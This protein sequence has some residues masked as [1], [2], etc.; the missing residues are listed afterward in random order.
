MA[1]KEKKEEAKEKV[2][3]IPLGDACSKHTTKRSIRAVKIIREFLQRHTK[4]T[5]VKLAMRL[6]DFIC[7]RGRS[8]PPRSIKVKAVIE[9][10]KVTADLAE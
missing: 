6:N 2:Y 7:A 3:M 9:G 1:K 4:K 5:D 8:K 10:D